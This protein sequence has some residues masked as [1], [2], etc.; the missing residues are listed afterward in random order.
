M[1]SIE[2]DEKVGYRLTA[3]M[4]IDLPRSQ[5]FDFFADAMELERI[6][7]PWLQFS[8]LTPPPIEIIKGKLLDYRLKLH[9][10]PINWRTE[11][12]EWEPPFR[13]VDQQLK[14]PYRRWY[15]EHTFEE[16]NGKTVV[17][18][19]VH[20]IPRG[21]KLLGSL[22]QRWFIGPDLEKIFR[23]RQDKLAEIFSEKIADRAQ[24]NFRSAPTRLDTTVAL[25]QLE[26]S[27][28][29]HS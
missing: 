9:G 25:K 14:G 22:L 28:G 2:T 29:L 8:V 5:V 27:S 12:S 7:P 13:F 19:N 21:G 15:H 6:T 23:F 11:I 24:L 20:Y 26:S 1:I 4:T 10:I 16:I 17:R 18:D 3:E